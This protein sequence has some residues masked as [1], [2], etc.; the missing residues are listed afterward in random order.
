MVSMG[1]VTS[2]SS[3]VASASAC[4]LHRAGMKLLTGFTIQIERGKEG[5]CQKLQVSQLT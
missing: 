3:T 4:G 5:I 2:R 1:Q